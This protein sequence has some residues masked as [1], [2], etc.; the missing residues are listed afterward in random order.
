MSSS[1]RSER[2]WRSS[3][4]GR[5]A[6]RSAPA[7][8]SPREAPSELAWTRPTIVP[9]CRDN[10]LL[11]T[12]IAPDDNA[13]PS[14]SADRGTW[15]G[16]LKRS[17]RLVLA[18]QILL[19]LA[20]AVLVYTRFGINDLLYRDEAI[21]AYGGQQLVEGVPPYVSI[22]DPKTPLATVLSGAAVA[23]GRAIGIDDVYAIRVGFFIL[24]C[25][26]LVAG[27]VA[28]SLLTGSA[29]AGWR[30]GLRQLPRV[31]DRRS[32]GRTPRHRGSC[33]RSWRRRC[34]S[35]A[36]GC[37]AVLRSRWP[38]WCGNRSSSMRSSRSRSPGS[39]PI[40]PIADAM[41]ERRWRGC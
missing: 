4:D 30:G 38:S 10:G 6:R 33:S 5:G 9:G 12:S 32:A 1:S 36:D 40:A 41:R 35:N 21:Y 26:T 29:V 31:R 8:H 17:G 13:A 14:G 15:L 23:V 27:F 19:V 22:I 18:A 7:H 20:V 25:L 28:A 2:R 39:A 16:R 11:E 3:A 34:C 24:T 37:W